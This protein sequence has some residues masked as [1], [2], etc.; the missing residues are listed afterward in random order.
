MAVLD[1]YFLKQRRCLIHSPLT[2]CSRRIEHSDLWFHLILA[3]NSIIPDR[4]RMESCARTSLRYGWAINH[5]IPYRELDVL[6]LR[7]MIGTGVGADLPFNYQFIVGKGKDLRG[8]TQ[9]EYRGNAMMAAQAEY[10]LNISGPLGATVFGG[11]ATVYGSNTPEQDGVVLPSVGL[12]VRYQVFESN[13]M[14]IGLDGAIG[15]N[16]WGVYFRIG[17]AF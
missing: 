13:K 7:V 2:R 4:E 17:E 10:R 14:N 15:R 5:F 8:Y 1:L 11:V 6:A 9:G 16:D 3:T 12:G